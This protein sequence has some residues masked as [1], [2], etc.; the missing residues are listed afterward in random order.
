[1]IKKITLLLTA[2]IC[3]NIIA[4]SEEN[5]KVKVSGY[6]DTYVAVENDNQKLENGATN[7]N[8]QLTYINPRKNNL[9]LNIAMIN[10]SANYGK[11]RSTFAIQAG[12]LV[13]T[14]YGDGSGLTKTPLI[15]QANVG[16]NLFDNV[17]MDA[18]YFMTH[19][20]GESFL[21]K[22]NWLSSHSLVTYFEP[23][24]QAGLRFSYETEKFNAQLHILNGNGMIEDNNSNKTLGLYL[25]Y[26]PLENLLISY[27]NVMGNEEADTLPHVNH[28]L[29][30]VCLQY[31]FNKELSAKAQ[32]DMATK[33]DFIKADKSK[34]DVSYMGASVALKY[35]FTEQLSSTFR[36]AYVN[37]E[38]G[39]YA[40]AL[41]G[42]GL[43][44]GG[45]Y[46]PTANSYIRLE[47]TMYSLDDKF[48]LFMDTDSKPTKSKMELM[49]N[50][51]IYLD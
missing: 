17:W 21:P 37:N 33:S 8:R 48:E 24:Y 29:H 32:F 20:G 18:G 27:A 34:D 13:N 9:G 7:N 30:N 6:I 49:L 43:T 22:D 11:A 16:Y 19:I 2:I 38:D 12:E 44:L 25:S 41:K 45:E 26:K 46:K 3:M 31:D 50:C 51:G 15:Q 40:P 28:I 1:M 39:L 4:N 10:V 42:M 36:F 35:A 47:G 5:L 23:F 14:A